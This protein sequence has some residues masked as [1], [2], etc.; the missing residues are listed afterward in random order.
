M[1][2]HKSILFCSMGGACW[3]MTCFYLWETHWINRWQE[4]DVDRWHWVF[5]FPMS[6]RSTQTTSSNLPSFIRITSI[7]ARRTNLINNFSSWSN[8]WSENDSRHQIDAAC[9][10]T[11][12]LECSMFDPYFR[13]VLIAFWINTTTFWNNGRHIDFLLNSKL[14]TL[15]YLLLSCFCM[16]NTTWHHSK[17]VHF[18]MM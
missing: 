5:F 12:S 16:Q 8:Q 14:S 18:A 13:Y 9:F 1:L 7:I 2:S 3:F 15:K 11:F 10:L 6:S 4:N 17:C